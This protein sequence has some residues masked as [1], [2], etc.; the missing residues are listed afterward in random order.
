MYEKIP[1]ER[2]SYLSEILEQSVVYFKECY[3]DLP[4][5]IYMHPE[6]YK[7]LEEEW[8]REPFDFMGVNIEILDKISKDSVFIY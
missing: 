3:E 1:V 4:V 6:V 5:I 2:S 7:S 8:G